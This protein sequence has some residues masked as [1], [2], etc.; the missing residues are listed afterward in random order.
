MNCGIT[1]N[2]VSDN[3]FCCA[4]DL[5]LTSLTTSGLQQLIDAANLYISSHGLRFNP[6]KTVCATF[7]KSVLVDTPT[8]Y[9]DGTE[10]QQANSINYLGVSL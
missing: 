7:G 10:L 4:D 1:I 9:L 3:V 5:L 8:W 2:N 6:A